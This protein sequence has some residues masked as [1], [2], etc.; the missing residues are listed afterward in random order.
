MTSDSLSDSFY[1]SDVI[2][3]SKIIYIIISEYFMVN[4]P[5]A[6]QFLLLLGYSTIV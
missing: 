1:Y 4:A 3:T 6:F 5:L 2:D